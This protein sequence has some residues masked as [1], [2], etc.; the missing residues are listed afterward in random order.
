MPTPD[1]LDTDSNAPAVRGDGG[2]ESDP[3]P[4]LFEVDYPEK[5]SRWKTGF[6]I[7]LILPMFL[8]MS[9][10]QSVGYAA[11]FAGFVTVFLRR[12]YPPWLMTAHTGFLGFY[13][14]TTAY[15]TLVTDNY[16]SFAS[17]GVPVRLLYPQP[18]PGSLS[19]WRVLFWKGA[20]IIP[21]LIVLMFL[22]LAV[23]VVVILAWFAIMFTGRYPRGMFAFVVG[24]QRWS[25]R[26]HG[27][28]ASFHDEYPPFSLSADARKAEYSTTV[29]AGVIGGFAAAGLAVAFIVAGAIALRAEV[30]DVD[31]AL[32]ERGSPSEIT[33]FGTEGDIFAQLSAVEDPAGEYARLPD[34]GERAI[35]FEV[36][37]FALGRTSYIQDNDA[38]LKYETRDG[39]RASTGARVV[40]VDDRSAP[41]QIELGD[42]AEVILVFVIPADAKPVS[43]TFKPDFAGF[44]GIRYKFVE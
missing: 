40:K 37:V 19:R 32:L 21:H 12:S 42:R 1:G 10:I 24:V 25:F 35:A 16:P 41:R 22:Y 20:L 11:M 7:I 27:Y 28:F 34:A 39:E 26:L 30:V 44:G 15:E 13:A 36:A 31:Y 43:L 29:V 4:T 5:L 8:F 3:Y 17:T 23:F 9:V 14:R 6:R 38:S 2:S 33:Q 18:E